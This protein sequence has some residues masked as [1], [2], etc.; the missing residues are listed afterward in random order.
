MKDQEFL[1]Q[2]RVSNEFNILM[3]NEAAQTATRE[4]LL[5]ALYETNKLMLGIVDEY[6]KL[7]ASIA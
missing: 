7:A 5:Q 4:E 2:L 3:S 6:N 1:D